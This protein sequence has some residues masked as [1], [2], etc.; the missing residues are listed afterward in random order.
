M[1]RRSERVAK[2]AKAV[3]TVSKNV[4]KSKPKPQNKKKPAQKKGNAEI[5]DVMPIQLALTPYICFCTEQQVELRKENPEISFVDLSRVLGL[6]WA[7][8]DE[9]SKE[10]CNCHLGSHPYCS[11]FPIELFDMF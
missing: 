2:A 9:E 8:L 7:T 5:D 1:V 6:T 3:S 11:I 10:V 4:A